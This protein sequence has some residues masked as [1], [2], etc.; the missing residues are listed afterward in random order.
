MTFEAMI[1]FLKQFADGCN[2]NSLLKSTAWG[3]TMRKSLILHDGTA[4][5]WNCD[6][7]VLHA[8]RYAIVIRDA[9][10]VRDVLV[11]NAICTDCACV[12]LSLGGRLKHALA[13]AHTGCWSSRRQIAF[14]AQ[15]MR[16]TNALSMST[17]ILPCRCALV[18]VTL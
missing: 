1:R 2:F 8:A 17:R 10:V 6:D 13:R 12:K 9:I 14:K 18:L 11:C 4:T 16:K 15:K 7:I 5:K 3:W